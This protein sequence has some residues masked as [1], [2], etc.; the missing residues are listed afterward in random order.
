[1]RVVGKTRMG[2]VTRQKQAVKMV[3]SA[4][5]YFFLNH[6]FSSGISSYLYLPTFPIL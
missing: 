2:P 6:G 1:L 4:N 5:I 3:N